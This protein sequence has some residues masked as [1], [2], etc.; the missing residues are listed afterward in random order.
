MPPIS[1]YI[2]ALWWQCPYV[3][4]VLLILTKWT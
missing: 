4:A 1:L 3:H 2:G